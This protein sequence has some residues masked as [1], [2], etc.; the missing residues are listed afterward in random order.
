MIAHLRGRV[1]A[2]HASA[3]V[4]DVGGVGY[5]VHVTGHDRVPPRGEQVELHTSLQVREDAMTLYGFTDRA[6][7]DLFELLLTAS[8]VG[9]KLAMA[10]LTTHRPDTLRSA[11]ATGDLD[12]LTQVP[13]IGKKGAQRMVLE[14]RDQVGR[15]GGDLDLTGDAP[16][17]AAGPLA[18]VREALTSLGYAAGEIQT[19]LADM[20]AD[21]DT[22]TL[23]RQ[24]LQRLGS[25]T[26]GAR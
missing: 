10:A 3:V 6:A 2:R 8:G 9:P 1:A 23:L 11:L 18:E 26:V 4:I 16:V 13:G 17:V 14:L 12:V 7:L 15:I 19:V 24:A 25:A 20:D 22:A 5:L 21:A